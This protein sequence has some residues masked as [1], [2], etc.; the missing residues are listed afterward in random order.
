MHC[1]PS[2]LLLHTLLT[3]DRRRKGLSKDDRAFFKQM[4]ALCYDASALG[5]IS[6]SWCTARA[7]VSK[8]AD[9][10]LSSVQAAATEY[11][12]RSPQSNLLHNVH[13][14][15]LA[16]QLKSESSS[17]KAK[18]AA[19]RQ[20][21]AEHALRKQA[22]FSVANAVA[23]H[24]RLAMYYIDFMSVA[25]RTAFGSLSDARR[26]CLNK[27][28]A[29]TQQDFTSLNLCTRDAFHDY[30]AQLHA[31]QPKQAHKMRARLCD[32]GLGRQDHPL[33]DRT[34]HRRDFAFD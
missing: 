20:A 17:D 1:Y 5:P 26:A 33:T 34:L 11:Q 6:D 30:I 23:L 14:Q 8:N 32:M 2:D 15:R 18:A 12:E 19:V 3:G 24:D 27:S 9:A 7:K 10:R 4:Q 29:E 13:M 25:Y 28:P 31:A 22:A 21:M 16:N